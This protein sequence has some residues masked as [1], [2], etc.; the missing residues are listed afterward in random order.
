MKHNFHTKW[1]TYLKCAIQW[2]L[3]YLLKYINRHHRLIPE[4]FHLPTR[5]PELP[6]S[7]QLL[8]YLM[9]LHVCLVY[10][11]H[12]NGIKKW[13]FVTSFFHLAS[14]SSIWSYISALH[15]FSLLNNILLYGYITFC[16]PIHQLLNIYLFTF[17]LLKI[18]PQ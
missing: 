14:L 13:S 1:F 3:I 15:S 10:T 9:S 12:I 2:F 5:K 11:F 7:R 18:I 8:N 16:L 17:W 6:S 4:H